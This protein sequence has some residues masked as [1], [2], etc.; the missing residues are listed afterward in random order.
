[1][2]IMKRERFVLSSD[3]NKTFTLIQI[4]ND[5][6]M[7]ISYNSI[8]SIY[9]YNKCSI[10]TSVTLNGSDGAPYHISLSKDGKYLANCGKGILQVFRN[11]GDSVLE[12][13]YEVPGNYLECIFDPLNI[14]NLL[15]VT[16]EYAEMLHCP[17]MEAFIRIPD[18][19]KGMAVNFDP[20]TGN[21]L[22]VSGIYNTIM[23]YNYEQDSLY[24]TCNHHG[25]YTDFYLAKNTIFHGD[26]YHLN[27]N[28]HAF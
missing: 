3:V 6:L 26:G 18:H 4:I 23:V 1:L 24:F 15:V 14:H 2:Q 28:E 13:I 20:V 9:N 10:K 12:R 27:L 25:V 17:D 19:I 16:Y 8:L 5:S 11:N 7:Y 22:F 21:L